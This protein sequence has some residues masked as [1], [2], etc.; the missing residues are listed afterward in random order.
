MAEQ[1][2]KLLGLFR[3]EDR[4]LVAIAVDPDSM[5]SALAV[6]RL[7]WRKVAE[8]RIATAT[9]TVRP[10]NI[11]MIR[12][13]R[14]PL[15]KL[16]ELELGRFT[17]VVMVDSQPSHH[18]EFGLLPRVDVVIDHH[19]LGGGLEGV[20]LVDVR[21]RY[22]AT[23]TIMTEYLRGAKI[24]PS[25]RLA[26]ALVYG[27]KTDTAGFSRPALEQDVAAFRFL[28]PRA[29][30]SVLRKIEFS[31]MRL[32]DLALLQRALER[33]ELRRHFLFVHMGKVADPD[34]LVQLADFFLKVDV[35][36]GCAVS[37]VCEGKLIVIL[38][39][40]SWRENAGK[41]AQRAFGELGT[42]GGH[43]ALARAEIPL[44]ALARLKPAEDPDR[45]GR[46]VMRR[47]QR[48]RSGR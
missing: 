40:A 11:A 3:P 5:A 25:A 26:T 44:E 29:E 41:L 18:E 31:E 19:P 17:R 21:P 4:V 15:E 32:G 30:Q 13:L 27:I 8:V 12:L 42:A 43:K 20:K 48:A 36:D 2:R 47:L 33:F 10:D 39:N 38:R 28:F 24:T 34:G 14:I 6:K 7:L 37:G 1:V 16:G 22:G 35:V 23:S 9:A 46:W 45:L